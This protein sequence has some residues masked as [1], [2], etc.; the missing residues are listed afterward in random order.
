M[1]EYVV[2]C[3]QAEDSEWGAHLPDLPSVVAI[4]ATWP[5]VAERIHG[6]CGRMQRTYT[7]AASRSPILATSLVPPPK[8]PAGFE[9][10]ERPIC[11]TNG[12]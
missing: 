4:G 11:L 7:S 5:Q 8:G 2:I 12:G 9:A 10:R 1:S 3:E 6:R